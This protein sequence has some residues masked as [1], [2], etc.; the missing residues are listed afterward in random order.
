MAQGMAHVLERGVPPN[1]GVGAQLQR[2]EEERLPFADRTTLA[3]VRASAPDVD[4][5]AS[6]ASHS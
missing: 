1:L 6:R 5:H 4:K 2:K 3:M